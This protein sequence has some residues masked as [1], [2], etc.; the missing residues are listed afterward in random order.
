MLVVGLVIQITTVL[1]DSVDTKLGRVDSLCAQVVGLQVA[2]DDAAALL[3]GSSLGPERLDMGTG[4]DVVP[5]RVRSPDVLRG[6]D[7]RGD[8]IESTGGEHCDL[9]E[10]GLGVGGHLAKS[11]LVLLDL[12]GPGCGSL[13][14]DMADLIG[15]AA[16][17][18]LSVLLEVDGGS[19]ADQQS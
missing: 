12:V 16:Q 8:G 17:N 18:M 10:E 7:E 11:G 9:V 15:S 4:S 6:L 19:S 14:D 1:L 5:L 13:V 2:T 3:A